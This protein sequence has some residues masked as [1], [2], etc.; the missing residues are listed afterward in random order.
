MEH[1]VRA[2]RR[3]EREEVFDEDGFTEQG[4][5]STDQLQRREGIGKEGE[6]KG[7]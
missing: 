5:Q 7:E 1:C 2:E 6:R 3:E 4:S